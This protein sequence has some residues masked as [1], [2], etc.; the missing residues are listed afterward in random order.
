MNTVQEEETQLTYIIV[1]D[2]F[3]KIHRTS[4]SSESRKGQ[5]QKDLHFRLVG[6]A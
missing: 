3:L 1:V 5:Q 4:S 6:S 2:V